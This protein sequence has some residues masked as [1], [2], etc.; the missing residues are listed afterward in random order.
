MNTWEGFKGFIVQGRG[1]DIVW[2]RTELTPIGVTHQ[3]G[4]RSAA[5]QLRG[6]ET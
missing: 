2:S 6:F 1:D 4:N 5:A 3:C